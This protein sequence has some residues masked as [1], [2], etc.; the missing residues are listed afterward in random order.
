MYEIEWTQYSKDDYN[1]LDGSQKV[2]V[3]KALD[4]IKLLGMKAGQPLN[5]DLALCKKLK[6]RKMGLRIVFREANGNVEVIQIV[7]IGKR[8]KETVYKAA[9][10][11]ISR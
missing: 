8:E 5:G 1:G 10:K 6:N 9:E 11:R 4:R 3:D 7:A 2:F